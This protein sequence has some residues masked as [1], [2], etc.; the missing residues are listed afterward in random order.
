LRFWDTKADSERAEQK[1][2]SSTPEA[3]IL[4]RT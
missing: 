1:V 3:L 4:G 2:K